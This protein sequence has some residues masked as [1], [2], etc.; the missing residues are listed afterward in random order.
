MILSSIAS[1]VRSVLVNPGI[2]TIGINM[3]FVYWIPRPA[4][5]LQVWE[6]QFRKYQELCCKWNNYKQDKYGELI[7]E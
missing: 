6:I 1:D 3:E 4:M 7:E 2:N 5:L